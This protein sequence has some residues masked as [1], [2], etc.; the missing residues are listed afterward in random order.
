MFW[1]L[2]EHNCLIINSL[3]NVS[4]LQ[5]RAKEYKNVNSFKLN[6]NKLE[7]RASKPLGDN[8]D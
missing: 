5:D 7:P 6:N 4:M 2:E 8:C 1:V 3:K